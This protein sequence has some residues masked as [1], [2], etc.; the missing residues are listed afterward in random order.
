MFYKRYFFLER[1][2]G[3]KAP[4]REP[5][6]F[7]RH[8]LQWDVLVSLP[9]RDNEQC[10]TAHFV[11]SPRKILRPMIKVNSVAFRTDL[12]LIMGLKTTAK[13]RIT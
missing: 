3:G 1:L 13:A 7:A 9:Y 2:G 10:Q 12:I 6:Y 4:T 8:V 11:V 5:V